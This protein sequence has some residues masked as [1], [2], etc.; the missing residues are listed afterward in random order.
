MT[1][2]IDNSPG[3]NKN[4]VKQIQQIVGTLLYL[5]QAVNS[6]L[7][8]PLSAITSEQSKATEC[9][10]EKI[11][12]LL[13]YYATNLNPILRYQASDMQLQVH[14]NASYLNETE[15]QSQVGGYFCMTNNAPKEDI[16]NGA[17]INPTGVLKVV[18]SSAAEVEVGA[19]F[20]NVKEAE[21]IHMARE[22]LR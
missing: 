4:E 14:S 3:L 7:L 18:V 21:V 13:V 2:N 10:H 6:T 11:N 5:A 17:I 9:T 8:V 16:D 1:E 20:V 15:A 19:L 12:Q 22:E